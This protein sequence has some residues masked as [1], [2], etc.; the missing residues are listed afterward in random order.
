MGIL[1]P[2]LTQNGALAMRL[3]ITKTVVMAALLVLIGS[4]LRPGV[5]E[6]AIVALVVLGIV[7]VTRGRRSDVVARQG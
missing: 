3:S 4:I 1:T 7:A 6:I 5:L 2:K